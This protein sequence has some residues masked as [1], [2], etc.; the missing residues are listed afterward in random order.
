MDE[1]VNLEE[2]FTEDSFWGKVKKYGKVAGY[3][4]LEKGLTLYYTFNDPNTPPLAKG[5]IG[6]ALGYFIFP[7]DA[8]PDVVPVVGYADDLGV[9]AAAIYSVAKSITQEHKDSA[10][11]KLIS[12]FGYTTKD[13]KDE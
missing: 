3:E 7:L 6:G 9:L 8:L 5:V 12:I 13:A 2:K 1:D 10:K 11:T 4:V